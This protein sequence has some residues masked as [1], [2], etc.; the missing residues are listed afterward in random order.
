MKLDDVITSKDIRPFLLYM[1]TPKWDAYHVHNY[2]GVYDFI[3][4]TQKNAAV[5]FKDPPRAARKIQGVKRMVWEEIRWT[6][7]HLKDVMG[8]W[9]GKRGHI[10]ETNKKYFEE[11]LDTEKAKELGLIAEAAMYSSIDR[12]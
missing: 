6:A 7:C 11:L 8:Y 12:S 2:V 4:D 5:T 10:C 9:E 1:G 3:L